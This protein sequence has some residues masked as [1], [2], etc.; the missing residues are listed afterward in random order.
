MEKYKVRKGEGKLQARMGSYNFK[1]DSQRTS[2]LKS[3]LS[4]KVPFDKRFEFGKGDNYV[5][6]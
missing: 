5:D 1:C 2:Y 4:K 3:D 6:I